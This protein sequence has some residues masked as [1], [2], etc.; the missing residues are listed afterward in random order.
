M[1]ECKEISCIALVLH[2]MLVIY[3]VVWLYIYIY[4]YIYLYLTDIIY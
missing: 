3:M 1:L 2:K 4:I